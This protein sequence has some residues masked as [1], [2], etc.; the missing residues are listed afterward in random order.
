VLFF[1]RGLT[2]FRVKEVKTLIVTARAIY[3]DGRLIFYN[4]GEI[5]EDGAEVIVNFERRPKM[6]VSSLRGSWA[7]Y[8]P[9]DFDLDAELR[10][11]RKEWEQEMEEIDE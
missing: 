2:E 10:K 4:S 6:P 1:P 9:K 7:K 8:F 11:I 5:P 3:K